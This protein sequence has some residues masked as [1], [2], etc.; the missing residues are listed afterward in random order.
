M[1]DDQFTEDSQRIK[2]DQFTEDDRFFMREALREAQAAYNKDEVPIGAVI[3]KDG[4]IIGRG[5]NLTVKE[6]DP[7]FHAEMVAMKN[8]LRTTGGWRLPNCRM[9]VTIEPCAMCAGAIVL[10]R[11][12]A[13][14]IG[15][16]DPKAGGAGS[17]FD[18]P[19]DKRL[20]H[21][22]KVYT[23]LLEDECKEIVQQFFKEKRKKG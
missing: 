9:Y 8:A 12:E 22:A 18:I 6:K 17:L 4:Q 11:L 19:R 15:A 7:T 5:H 23:G 21:Q 3:V 10:A 16:S 13:L 14:Y 20:N 2:E 1:E